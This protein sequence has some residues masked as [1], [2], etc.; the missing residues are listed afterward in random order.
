MVDDNHF[1]LQAL[2]IA[3]KYEFNIDPEKMCEKAYNGEEAL[4]KVK[5]NVALNKN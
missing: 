1:N 2:E 3:F 5:E 4:E